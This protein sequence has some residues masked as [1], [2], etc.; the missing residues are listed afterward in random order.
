[1]ADSPSRSNL[2][3]PNSEASGKKS[4]KFS[5]FSCQ[6][7][8]FFF[9]LEILYCHVFPYNHIIPRTYIKIDEMYNSVKIKISFQSP[10]AQNARTIEGTFNMAFVKVASFTSSYI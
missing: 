3:S 4:S 5:Y 8:V 6:R 2:V 10:M 9:P 7:V 1:M